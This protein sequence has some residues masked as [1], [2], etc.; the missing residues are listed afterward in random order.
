ML[1]CFCSFIL[2]VI[3]L[4]FIEPSATR[5]RNVNTNALTST[6]QML[7]IVEI[8]MPYLFHF[9]EGVGSARLPR[10][11]PKSFDQE[12]VENLRVRVDCT[13]LII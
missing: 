13:D 7:N 8:K 3:D 1:Y 10:F 4:R 11:S 9:G 5:S 2:D 6:A 12:I